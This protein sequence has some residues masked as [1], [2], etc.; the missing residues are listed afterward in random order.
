MKNKIG[1][2]L[3]TS[4]LLAASFS[5]MSADEP[6]WGNPFDLYI[7]SVTYSG[8]GITGH[9][10]THGSVV[11]GATMSICNSRLSTKKSMHT[12]AGDSQIAEVPCYLKTTVLHEPQIATPNTNWGN[13]GTTP[14]YTELEALKE[15]Y[16][17]ATY[18]QRIEALKR[19]FNID[20]FRQEFERLHVKSLMPEKTEKNAKR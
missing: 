9:S 11:T 13:T 18:E 10:G 8:S 6:D 15:K 20:G 7:G 16:N 1:N 5:V 4:S 14:I 19:E 12:S 3:I 2:L 17:I